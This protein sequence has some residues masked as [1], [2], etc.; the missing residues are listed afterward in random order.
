MARPLKANQT[1]ER[2]NLTLPPEMGRVL[3]A[4]S[5]REGRSITEI[6]R[7]AIGELVVAPEQSE[8]IKT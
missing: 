5:H 4:K 8:Q 6:I 2:V 3:V 7:Q 1:G